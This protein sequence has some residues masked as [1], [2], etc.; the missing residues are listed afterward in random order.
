MVESKFH[1]K[2]SRNEF[3]YYFTMKNNATALKKLA[4]TKRNA[5]CP[6]FAG[7]WFFFLWTVYNSDI[8]H[9]L[10]IFRRALTAD[11]NIYSGG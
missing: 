1:N 5:D 4:E 9:L 3:F 8:I 11:G 6:P 7:Q 10:I 2:T